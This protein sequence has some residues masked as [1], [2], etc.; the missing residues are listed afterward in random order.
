[1]LAQRALEGFIICLVCGA[2]GHDHEVKPGQFVLSVPKGLARQPFD[3]IAVYS[4]FQVALGDGQAQP[5]AIQRIAPRQHREI[6][7]R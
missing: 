2:L 4:P 1:M 5:G 6:G 7:I 3:S